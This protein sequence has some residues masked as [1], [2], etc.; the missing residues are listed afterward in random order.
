VTVTIK[1]YV[2]LPTCEYPAIK[3]RNKLKHFIIYALSSPIWHVTVASF[4]M[5]RLAV[6]SRPP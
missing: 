2:F 5:L 6:F 4:V 3:C 1:H